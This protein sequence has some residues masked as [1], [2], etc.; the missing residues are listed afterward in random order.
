[1]MSIFQSNLKVF[2]FVILGIL[3]IKLVAAV[4]YYIYDKVK[5]NRLEIMNQMWEIERLLAK[6]KI[7]YKLAR[8]QQNRIFSLIKKRK[9]PRNKQVDF[10]HFI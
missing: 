7:S 6:G 3:L 8:E 9:Y 10:K 4:L 1:M 2:I 5:D